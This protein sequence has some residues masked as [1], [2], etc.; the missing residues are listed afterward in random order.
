[1]FVFS[2]KCLWDRRR[3]LEGGPWSFDKFLLVLKEPVGIGRIEE[4]GF[5][6]ALFWVQIYNL[7][8]AYL[9]K[10]VGLFLG[11]MIGRVREVDT[12]TGGYCLGKCLRDLDGQFWRFTGFYGDPRGDMRFHSW[13]LLRRLARLSKLPW[14][15]GGDFNEV[16]LLDEKLG[17]RVKT[18][19]AL[20]NFRDAVDDCCLMDMGFRGYKFTWSNRQDGRELIQE[21]LDRFLCSMSWRSLFPNAVNTHLDWGGSDH[22]ALL[23][24]NVQKFRERDR[25]NRWGARFHFDEAWVD[26]EECRN[27]VERAWQGGECLDGISGLTRSVGL[28]E[29]IKSL[30][31]NFYSHLFASTSPSV[32]MIENV[33]QAVEKRV[34][35][36]MNSILAASFTSEEVFSALNQMAPGLDGL[37]ALFYQK[38]WSIVGGKVSRAVLD[39]LNNGAGFGVMGEVMV[40]LIPKVKTPVRVSDFRPI[41]LCNVTYKLVVKVLANRLKLVLGDVVDSSQ[42][43]FV[44]G[45][46]ITDNVVVGFECLHH[47]IGC[48][49]GPKGF[50]AFKLDM[51]KA[52]DR[53]EWVFLEKIMLKLGF[54]VGWVQKVMGCVKSASY[55]FIINGEPRG[56]VKP[57]RGLRQGCPLFPYLFLL[58]AE[59]LTSLLSRATLEGRLHGIKVARYA[60]SISHLLFADDSLIFTRATREEGAVLKRI[61]Q[62]YEAASGQSVNYEKS[63]LTFSPNVPEMTVLDIGN[64]F[65]VDVVAC[66]EKYLG[67]PSSLGRNKRDV[68]RSILD[69]VWQKLQG[70]KGRLFS[71]GGKEVLLKAVV[72]AIPSY[73]M[74]CF[75]L[76]VSLGMDVQRMCADFW[77][78]SEKEKR[79]THWVAWKK[80][81]FSKVSGGMGFRDFSSFNQAMLAK[82]GWRL[83]MN[84]SSLMTRVLKA[85]YFPNT[86]FLSSALG[87]RPSFVWRS[88]LWGREVLKKGLRWKVGDGQ[89]ISVYE[90]SWLP[91]DSGFRVLSPR[92]LP[93]G[94]KVAALLS[95]PGCW[96]K[97]LVE[98]YFNSEEAAS[99]L[100]IP[101]CSRPIEDS[102]IWHFDKRGFFSVKSAYN[103]ALSLGNSDV[104]SCSRGFS[105]WWRKLWALQ[106]PSKVKIFCWRACKGILPT[107]DVLFRRGIADSCFC[108][109]CGFVLDSADHAVWGCSSVQLLWDCCPI[110]SALDA[111]KAMDFFDRV[112][113][114]FSSFSLKI[115]LQFL[116]A[117]WLSWFSR[118]QKLHGGNV[119]LDTDLWGRAA[120]FLDAFLGSSQVSVSCPAGMSAVS[121]SCAVKLWKPPSFGLK[122]NVDAAVDISRG[123]FGV[124]IIFR[125]CFGGLVAAVS[126]YFSDFFYVESAEAKAIL[127]GFQMAVELDLGCSCFEFESDALNVVNLC[128][129]GAA[130]LCEVGNIVYDIRLSF[131]YFLNS[132]SFVPRACNNVAHVLAKFA[133]GNQLN[134]V[135]LESFPSWLL[136]LVESD[137]VAAFAS[138]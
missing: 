86:S 127:L 22:K 101:L 120:S 99:I 80:M 98:F 113:W 43:A 1:M 111:F 103:V 104:P 79:K 16:L 119:L 20:S 50:A 118:N 58:C 85:K 97:G 23:V 107:R 41:S 32:N 13:N 14:L 83:L 96:S 19:S 11:D 115:S 108:A 68:F 133:V 5:S 78:G 34:N 67:L 124:G 21:R 10:E 109:L 66:H 48:K 90:D 81:C 93:Y 12:G 114:V 64:I 88:I 63:A 71:V 9:N 4:L 27:I 132:L 89:I 69:R 57:S 8:L 128:C 49:R 25:V 54:E 76:P 15:V 46:L 42:S 59:G 2:F 36:D 87:C 38:F 56:C 94:V 6:S 52:Y 24:N 53:V 134:F 117:C 95:R 61:L 73:A 60:P 121:S 45:R 131:N 26:D 17:G 123:L 70:W 122:V 37:P 33:V 100:S 112:V 130:S 55:S 82:Q 129:G 126:R 102:L 92:L 105:P 29:D 135:W 18:L 39:I 62:M 84:P 7:P 51:S 77:W 44:P 40:A 137:S 35:A 74:S 91:K 30:V 72:Q 75:K 65:N 28:V 31:S 138:S 116:V 125:D 106:L 110:F 136:K 47:L 3:V